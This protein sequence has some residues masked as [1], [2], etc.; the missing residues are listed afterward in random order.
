MEANPLKPLSGAI[1][2]P[3]VITFRA[4]GWAL[5][6]LFLGVLI[7]LVAFFFGSGVGGFLIG[8]IGVSLLSFALWYI[9]IKDVRELVKAHKLCSDNKK[10]IDT[11]QQTAVLLTEMSFELQALAFKNSQQLSA[12]VNQVRQAIAGWDSFPLVG[13]LPGMSHLVQIATSSVAI[14]V[15][16]LSKVIVSIN[17]SMN[18]VI[19]NTRTALVEAKPKLLEEYLEQLQQAHAG[20]K[21]LLAA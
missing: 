21:K 8:L 1:A 14:Q 12:V 2:D 5:A 3:L 6:L 18:Q 7:L 13:Q 11:V 17:D 16:D 15:T 10:L 19:G 9:Y 4:G 20:L